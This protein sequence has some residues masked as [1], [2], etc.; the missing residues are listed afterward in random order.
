MHYLFYFGLLITP[1]IYGAVPGGEIKE[2]KASIRS[3][4]APLIPH[5]GTTERPKELARFRVDRCEKHKIDWPSLLFNQQQ[6]ILDYSFK[7][8]CDIEGTLRPLLLKPFPAVLKLRNLDNYNRIEAM[9]TV[10]ADLQAR[11]LINLEMRDGIL[12]GPKGR[13]KFEADYKVRMNPLKPKEIDSNE[14]GEIRISE[15]YGQKVDIK[16]KIKVR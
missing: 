4:I 10:S 15:I 11:P 3:L 5:S 6:I 8:G 13:V 12:I 1:E 2:A 9:N 16:E 14:G 7:E